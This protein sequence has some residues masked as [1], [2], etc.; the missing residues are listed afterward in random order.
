MSRSIV[1]LG[2]EKRFGV[3]KLSVFDQVERLAFRLD[4]SSGLGELELGEMMDPE[5]EGWR[6]CL[7][8]AENNS[9]PRIFCLD[10]DNFVDQVVR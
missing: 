9:G 6:T 10:M 1:Q 4:A 5:A 8:V 3:R 2:L 7:D